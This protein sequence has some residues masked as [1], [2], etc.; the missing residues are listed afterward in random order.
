VTLIAYD[1]LGNG[2]RLDGGAMFGNA[3]RA[4]WQRWLAPDAD[5]RVALSCR[6]LLLRAGD[7][8]VLFETGVGAFFEPKLKERFGVTESEHVLLRSLRARGLDHEDIDVVVLSHLHFDHAGGL[9]R[10]YIAGQPPEL[11]F[12]HARFLTSRTAFERAEHPH[13]RDRASFI[14][15]LTELL[16][17][18][19]RLVL[20]GD[21]TTSD[22][23][24]P[25][26]SFRYSHGHTPGMLHTRVSGE[27]QQLFFCADLVP[28]IPWLHLPVTMG[29]DRNAEA[30]I[31]E[32][33]RWLREFSE[34]GTWLFFTHDPN[35][36]MARVGSDERG[37]KIALQAQAD[38]G[39][40]FDLDAA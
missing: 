16:R 18:S 10:P 24:G 27:R 11:L 32:K 29:Y 34:D 1:V 8:N 19:G 28:G 13:L 4:L 9:L 21:E 26:F 15:G 30:L 35:V 22:V 20:L 6:A 2:Q 31:D 5:N 39:D 38:L 40:G 37:R 14:P 25:A 12:P 7:K 3:P 36:A 17:N 33:E 23:L